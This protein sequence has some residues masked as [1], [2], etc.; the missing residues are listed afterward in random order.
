VVTV[1][2]LGHEQAVSEYWY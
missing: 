1:T 2:L